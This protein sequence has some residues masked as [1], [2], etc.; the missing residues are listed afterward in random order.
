M[1][2][3]STAEPQYL[4]NMLTHNHS[5]DTKVDEGEGFV[6]LIELLH[7]QIYSGIAGVEYLRNSTGEG[8]SCVG[9]DSKLVPCTDN[10]GMKQ[11]GNQANDDLKPLGKWL[12]LLGLIAF[13]WKT[14]KSTLAPIH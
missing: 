11:P 12:R 4:K 1:T 10:D 13:L 5:Q 2:T 9:H 8:L 6:A 14:Q 3:K 7:C